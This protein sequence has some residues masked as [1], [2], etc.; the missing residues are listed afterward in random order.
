MDYTVTDNSVFGIFNV[1]VKF[2]DDISTYIDN[3]KLCVKILDILGNTF[4]YAEAHT[5]IIHIDD[6]VNNVYGLVQPEQ[7][8]PVDRQKQIEDSLKA[9]AGKVFLLS[10]NT[11]TI[12]LM[13]KSTD[14][15][16][17]TFGYYSSRVIIVFEGDDDDDDMD[18]TEIELYADLFPKVIRSEMPRQFN[19]AAEDPVLSAS[20]IRPAFDFN[21]GLPEEINKNIHYTTTSA[22]CVN[23]SSNPESEEQVPLYVSDIS[24]FTINSD[25]IETLDFEFDWDNAESYLL[26]ETTSKRYD[27]EYTKSEPAETTF[28][29]IDGFSA[30]VNNYPVVQYIYK[31]TPSLYKNKLVFS[32]KK[33]YELE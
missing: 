7:G 16:N 25:D 8:Q 11:L 18:D 10:N 22:L 28:E 20:D 27:I 17:S 6:I 15:N 26:D 5:E 4:D 13:A 3:N 32:L 14:A 24:A 1:Q 9:N 30:T 33:I 31:S 21:Q 23:T 29:I 2:K 12:I 19:P